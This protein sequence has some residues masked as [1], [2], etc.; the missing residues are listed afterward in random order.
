MS[1][2][3]DAKEISEEDDADMDEEQ[4]EECVLP[5]SWR[6]PTPDPSASLRF[7]DTSE[8]RLAVAKQAWVGVMSYLDPTSLV[9]LA[10][11]NRKLYECVCDSIKFFFGLAPTSLLFIF[12][13]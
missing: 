3:R 5:D 11:T 10:A 1:V 8:F 12:F 9:M 7:K 6:L 13:S 4:D 2:G